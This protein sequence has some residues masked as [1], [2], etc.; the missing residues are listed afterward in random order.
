M[1]WIT[2]ERL[3]SQLYAAIMD[4]EEMFATRASKLMG[5]VDHLLAQRE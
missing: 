3:S 1:H 5:S 2:Y 4:R